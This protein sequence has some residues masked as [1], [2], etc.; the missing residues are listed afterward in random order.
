[1]SARAVIRFCDP[2]RKVAKI[3][4]L[5]H[6]SHPK[7]VVPCLYDF[8]QKIAD[9]CQTM[10]MRP[11]CLALL[12]FDKSEN[13]AELIDEEVKNLDYIYTVISISG[14]KGEGFPKV[15]I[16]GGC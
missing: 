6:N 8:F 4:Y 10:F 13:W 11:D 2:D 16:E 15:E 5:H 3:V 12:W 1:M 7:H 14:K 9:R